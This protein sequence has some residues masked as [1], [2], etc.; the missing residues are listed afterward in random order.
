MGKEDDVE[1]EDEGK[2]D[3]VKNL[4]PREDDLP[5][6]FINAKKPKKLQFMLFSILCF[7][8]TKN[9]KLSEWCSS[10]R[11]FLKYGQQRGIM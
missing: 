9:H 11:L 8:R 1:R 3:W 4:P 7:L 6:I 10:S 2:C 5:G